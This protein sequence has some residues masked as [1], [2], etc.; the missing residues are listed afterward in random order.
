MTSEPVRDSEPT[1]ALKID[2]CSVIAE[3]EPRNELNVSL[4]PLRSN[5]VIE[6]EPAR[7]R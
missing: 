3:D 5:A 4:R 6:N 2:V 7:D 1:K